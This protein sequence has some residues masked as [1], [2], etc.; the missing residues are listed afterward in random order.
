MIEKTKDVL[1]LIDE[2]NKITK[3][4]KELLHGNLEFEY[5]IY[6]IKQNINQEFIEIGQSINHIKNNY[7]DLYL[8]NKSYIDVI[9]EQIDNHIKLNEV[10]MQ[11]SVDSAIIKAISRMIALWLS[12]DFS[13]EEKEQY[14]KDITVEIRNSNTDDVI[15]SVERIKTS[16]PEIYNYNKEYFEELRR[17]TMAEKNVQDIN[18]LS[19]ENNEYDEDDE[20]DDNYNNTSLKSKILS[21]F[22]KK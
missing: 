6:Q 1:R 13:K 21:I 9:Q 19:I 3:V 7:E 14:Y 11:I 17:Y 15:N 8:E 22:K 18:S 10:W 16:Y 4:L 20:Y 12:G 5:I 2:D